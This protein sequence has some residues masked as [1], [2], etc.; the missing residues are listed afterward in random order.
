MS[1]K[2]Y[3]KQNNG[4][5]RKSKTSGGMARDTTTKWCSLHKTTLHDN[6]DCY[7][8]GASRQNVGGV[9]FDTALGAHSLH[10]ESGENPRIKIDGG[11]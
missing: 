6:A 4:H 5:A 10:S 7:K 3:D 2:T 9:F 11:F 1:G 8:Q